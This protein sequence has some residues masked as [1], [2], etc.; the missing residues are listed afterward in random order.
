[1]ARMSIRIDLDP[2]G[3]LGPGKVQLLERIAE[4]GSIAAAGRAMDMSYRRAW[5]LVAD[6]NGCFGEPLVKA[7]MGGR[8]G[9]GGLVDGFRPRTRRL[10]PRDRA[11][12]GRG[13]G[14][15]SRGAADC[16]RGEGA[17]REGGVERLNGVGRVH[18]VVP[19][20]TT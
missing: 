4:C 8:D 5:R 15:A 13:G 10:L 11:R 9:G 12:C 3:R 1:M 16:G 19:A 20:E 18:A 17:R 14:T 7:Q 2:S 6:L